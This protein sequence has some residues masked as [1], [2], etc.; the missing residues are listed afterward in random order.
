MMRVSVSAILLAF[1]TACSVVETRLPSSVNFKES[2]Q[3]EKIQEIDYKLA[4]LYNREYE[5]DRKYDRTQTAD[6][7]NPREAEQLKAEKIR[8]QS[9]ISKLQSERKE[10]EKS[11]SAEVATRAW[12]GLGPWFEVQ[13]PPN[14]GT[15]KESLTI[16][17]LE[18]FEIEKASRSPAFAMD[19]RAYTTYHLELQNRL[20]DESV[21]LLSGR[22]ECDADIRYEEGLLFF[23]TY[24]RGRIYD[25]TWTGKG[26]NDQDLTV[27]FAYGVKE[28]RVLLKPQ[29]AKNWTHQINI[30]SLDKLIPSATK[31]HQ[32]LEVCARPTGFSGNDPVS[33]FWQQD[34][35]Q[36]SCPRTFEKIEMLRDPIKAFNAR[37]RSLTGADVPKE[38]YQQKNP[39]VKLDF[40][41]A[42]KLDFIWV[43]SLNFSADFSGTL[44][45]QALT[46]HADRGAQ[47]RILVPEATMG[48]KD[49]KILSLLLGGRPNVRVQ[50]YQYK[51]SNGQDGSFFDRFHRVNHMKL[52]IGYSASEPQNT[53]LVTGGRNVTDAYLFYDKPEYSRYP[54][55]IDYARGERP[56][57]YYDDFE[58]EIRGSEFIEAV[59]AQIMQF[60]HRD[61]T[62]KYLRSTNL[63]VTR[64]LAAEQV[65]P[66]YNLTQKAP[67]I[68]HVLSVP[69][70]DNH[71]LEKFYIEMFD[72]AQ[73]EILLTTPYFRP[74]AAISEAFGRAVKRGVKI[75]VLTR[76]QLAGDSVPKIAEDVNKKGV[77][78]HLHDLEMYEWT[79]PNSIL[80][81]KL[82]VIDQKLSFISSVNM[83]MR[84]FI[85][86]TESGVL[87]LHEDTAQK[88]KKEMLVYFGHSQRLTEELKIKWLNGKLIDIFDSYF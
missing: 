12:T 44:L 61:E 51:F 20:S 4:L 14:K 69:Y 39:L 13:T 34:Y 56:F 36:V 66:L 47:I 28:C 57:I 21:G 70:T 78:H 35:N 71:Q 32:H 43:S 25:F 45:A 38:A 76:I 82:L 68:R 84:S 73:K 29:G 67:L 87:I 2:N 22:L 11:L 18:G 62:T 31:F 19:L 60:W 1:L 65:S 8:I 16:E 77:N 79:E 49:K 37:I 33:F 72:S 48:K 27:G 75:K 59:L 81:T 7:E 63:N 50:Y 24:K 58:A 17:S 88:L 86:D 55:L 6:N 26:G 5:V 80:H 40:S 23:K 54:W 85:H 9:D 3:A 30:A 53:F 10:L 46:Y 15:K 52:L 41:K 64:P 74:S 83:N 42:P